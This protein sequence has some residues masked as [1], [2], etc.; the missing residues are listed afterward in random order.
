MILNM[1]DVAKLMRKLKP[2]KTNENILSKCKEKLIKGKKVSKRHKMTEDE[3]KIGNEVFNKSDPRV[4]QDCLNKDVWGFKNM[5]CTGII[6]LKE[7]SA[8]KYGYTINKDRMPQSLFIQDFPVAYMPER[9]E[10]IPI[11]DDSY[12]NWTEHPLTGI[13]FQ[14]KAAETNIPHFEKQLSSPYYYE[15]F[16]NRYSEKFI[17]GKTYVLTEGKRYTFGLEFEASKGVLPSYLRKQFNVSCVRDG[18]LN[19]HIDRHLGGPEY[20]TG[21]LQG[22]EGIQHTQKLCN[23]LSKRHKINGSC[24]LHV[25]VG[26]IKFSRLEVVA[27]YKLGLILQ[28]SL[29]QLQPKSRR[30]NEYCKT[31]PNISSVWD[32]NTKLTPSEFEIAV[33]QAYEAMYEGLAGTK[34]YRLMNKLTNHPRGARVGYDHSTMRYCWLNMVPSMFNIRGEEQRRAGVLLPN[35][36]VALAT[37]GGRYEVINLTTGHTIFNSDDREGAE[38]LANDL[39][40]RTVR[41]AS[42]QK[43]RPESYT[44]EFR[45]HYGTT[46]FH[47]TYMW[48]LVCFAFVNYVENYQN[49]ILNRAD[50]TLEEVIK[51]TFPKFSSYILNYYITKVAEFSHHEF[52]EERLYKETNYGEELAILSTKDLLKNLIST[53]YVYNNSSPIRNRQEVNLPF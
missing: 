16:E 45:V 23:E 8:F 7:D 29:F 37:P 51:T 43:Q 13:F 22:D 9:Q 19:N 44:F 27:A 47:T 46:D 3:V 12:K 39:N 48:L 30:G 40:Q 21:V 33:I 20:V 31:L 42:P 41:E 26:N 52:S 15:Q 24:G 38:K 18:S 6:N 10:Y 35:E 4:A 25:H 53:Q 1:P 5:M 11:F 34:P 50:I 49:D 2:K 32:I 17:Q 14:P 28:D 36:H